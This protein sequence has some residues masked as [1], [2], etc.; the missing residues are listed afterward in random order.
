[1]SMADAV[2]GEFLYQGHPY[3]GWDT[4]KSKYDVT[5][6]DRSQLQDKMS[7]LLKDM[8][9][10]VDLQKEVDTYGTPSYLDA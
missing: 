8:A 2:R 7:S 3:E 10:L 6:Q 5:G 9:R 4:W 1:M